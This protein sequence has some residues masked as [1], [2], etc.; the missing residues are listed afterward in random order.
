MV[1]DLIRVFPADATSFET[2]GL[3]ALVEATK[4]TVHE[5][6]NGE[7]ELELEYPVWGRHSA[8]L[9]LRN[10]IVAKS[11][12]YGSPQAFRIYACSK[13]IN[14]VI[15]YNA[16]HISYDLSGYPL[17]PLSYNNCAG[18][19][20]GLKDHS[21]KPH[22]FTFWTDKTT[23]AEFKFDEP[24]STRAALGGTEG[25]ILDTYHGDYE[26]DNFVVK[27]YNK[28]G[29]D[30]GVTIRYG[31]DMT[32]FSQ[33]EN[34][35]GVYTAVY[36]YWK[37]KDDDDNEILYELPDKLVPV[38]GSYSFTNVLV[39]DF[40]SDFDTE[41]TE[42]QFRE[43]VKA[44]IKE[45]EIGK[46]EVSFEVS[47]FQLSQAVEYADKALLEQIELFD[48]V[49]VEFTAL[50]VS[51][52][53]TVSET[54]YNAI[55]DRYESITLGSIR[56]SISDSVV[57]NSNA[58][59]ESE[60]RTSNHLEKAVTDAT[61]WITNGKGYMVAVK[62][63]AGNWIEL[64]SLDE[65]SI[66]RARSVWRWNNGGFGHSSTGYNG[67]YRTAITQDGHIVAD[68]IDTGVLTA[69]IITAGVLKDSVGNTF[70][71]DLDNGILRMTPSELFVGGANINDKF[72][73]I[74][75]SFT[76]LENN[77]DQMIADAKSYADQIVGDAKTEQE[78][79]WKAAIGNA[80]LQ[81]DIFNALTMKGKLE[82]L[83]MR[84]GQLYVSGSY[85]Y[86]GVMV[87]GGNNNVS[88][89]LK[90]RNAAGK[91]LMVFDNRGI[92][93][94]NNCKIQWSDISGTDD[95]AKKGEIPTDAEIVQ[96]IK[97]NRTTI[98]DKDYIASLRVIAGSVKS[99]TVESSTITGSTLTGNTI[100]VGGRDNQDG[101][102]Y[103]KNANGQNVVTLNN[104]GITLG[105]GYKIQWSNISGTDD[106]AKKSD[107][108]TSANIVDVI[109]KNK[110]TI[111]TDQYIASLNVI[112]DNLNAGT[113]LIG[114]SMTVGGSNN[115][116]G[117][118]KVVNASGQTMITLNNQGI[119]FASG[120][121]IKYSDISGTPS[122]PSVP[123]NNDI[124]NLVKNNRT[125]II[126][127][128]YIASMYIV[129]D[130]VVSGSITGCTISGGT[131]TGSV[132]SSK[133]YSLPSSSYFTSAGS[134]FNLNDGSFYSKNFS[135]EFNG[136]A[137]FRGS[138][139]SANG[140]FTGKLSAGSVVSSTI[141]GSTI[142]GST[143]KSEQSGNSS[144]RT[145]ISGSKIHLY[146]NASYS[147]D[148]GT[149][150]PA[151]EQVTI[152]VNSSTLAVEEVS[153][154]KLNA[155]NLLMINVAGVKVA[156]MYKDRI[157]LLR[158][159]SASAGLTASGTK[160]RIV[161]T[162]DYSTRALYCYEMPSPMFGDIGESVIGEDGLVFIDI[163]DV[164]AETV[165]TTIEYQVFLQ[166]EGPGDLWVKEKE[167]GYFVV[168]GT[169]NLKF[170]WEIK[171]KQ[172][173][174]EYYRLDKEE[175]EYS[176]PE[177]DSYEY[178]IYN[179]IDQLIEEQYE[180]QN[181]YEPGFPDPSDGI[182]AEAVLDLQDEI[183]LEEEELYEDA[184]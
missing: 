5:V 24:I 97:D 54:T 45:N 117:T 137:H 154:I 125:T 83:F 49:H 60:R 70:Y 8:D 61:K 112:A 48:T 103:V 174:Y 53:A 108:P 77:V 164:F 102:I 169:P 9:V 69:T 50:G 38:E 47:F 59:A 36:P 32:E 120:C 141:T 91:D 171:A 173:D 52:S 122:I 178:D 126:D 57:N 130:S 68:F 87:V 165:T 146:S 78:E 20:Q 153:G 21:L 67:D 138:L 13:P 115:T 135:V 168:E 142:T 92:T 100:T 170:S 157:E 82:G 114:T 134:S 18:A 127:E 73:G 25:S 51:S 158:K 71:L 161:K 81:E 63:E 26:F 183:C 75:K 104:Q 89:V 179:E 106:I 86:G 37:G 167:H 58:I 182:L 113:S 160:P 123:S 140:T 14:G 151:K 6:G 7:F 62:D 119:T 132:L 176:D 99:G 184:Q 124:V 4:C 101:S 90:V 15:R 129:A 139:D 10:L 93:F 64:C 136:N 95:I 180:A 19:M 30:R 181:S 144:V 149:I 33:E 133:N 43:Y 111:I 177:P 27:L 29:T 121:K 94:S 128:N 79:E 22:N 11:H 2:N 172:R 148:C 17:T 3:G 12:P 41:P 34:I 23:T 28:R 85:I 107:I 110:S 105:A 55:T 131:I 159:V 88:G 80:K 39:Q 175:E 145:E 166:K 16:Q 46:P 76:D 56:A 44:W 118:I 96:N 143:L 156:R 31:K 74:D 66:E 72:S 152:E 35:S 84:E 150:E 163:D 116:N 65:P 42:S 98:I 40:S 147:N 1:H 155:A 162:P 109:N